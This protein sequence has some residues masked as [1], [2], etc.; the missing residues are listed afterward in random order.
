[1]GYCGLSLLRFAAEVWGT[2]TNEPKFAVRM[3]DSMSSFG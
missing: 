1:M 3:P 2:R